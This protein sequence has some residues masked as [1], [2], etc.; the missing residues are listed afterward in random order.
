[1]AE[2]NYLIYVM[3]HVSALIKTSIRNG[4]STGM[5]HDNSSIE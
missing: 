1:M 2:F 5:K 3:Q 4:K